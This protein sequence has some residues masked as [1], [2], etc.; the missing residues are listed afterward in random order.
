VRVCGFGGHGIYFRSSSDIVHL[1]IVEST[2]SLQAVFKFGLGFGTGVREKELLTVNLVAGDCGLALGAD[3]P[4]NKR[5]PV[6]GPYIRVL[7]GI[8]QDH[9]I[10]VEE[11]RI[12]F[13]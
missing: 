4:I 8:N 12:T 3:K 13:N 1:S 5:L 9:A 11:L 6:F 10:L 7:G 2:H